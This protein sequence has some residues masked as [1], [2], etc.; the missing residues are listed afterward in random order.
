MAENSAQFADLGRILVIIPTYNERENVERITA[1]VRAAIPEADILIADDNSP[2]G[3]GAIADRLS[4]VDDQIHVMHRLGKEGL[5]AAYF[6]R[7]G[8]RKRRRRSWAMMAAHPNCA[9]PDACGGDLLAWY[10]PAED[11]LSATGSEPLA[12]VDRKRR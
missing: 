9:R 1:R 3:T 12:E 7:S 11:T 6:G 10:P 2:D 8:G 5:G 4:R